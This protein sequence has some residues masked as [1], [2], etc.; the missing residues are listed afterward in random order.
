[1]PSFEREY[2]QATVF[3]RRARVEPADIAYI[4]AHTATL[5]PEPAQW[6]MPALA[7]GDGFQLEFGLAGVRP[8]P[9][10]IVVGT[11][12]GGWL[13]QLSTQHL[14]VRHQQ[15]VVDGR[16]SVARE[17]FPT[18]DAFRDAV[19][20]ACDALPGTLLAS[21]W[22]TRLA[23][24][25]AMH[26]GDLYP[27]S[28]VGE[29]IGHGARSPHPPADGRRFV[30]VHQEMEFETL[31]GRRYVWNDT[32]RTGN[33]FRPDGALTTESAAVF[34]IELQT[35]APEPAPGESTPQLDELPAVAPDDLR[36]FFASND[37]GM[38]RVTQRLRARLPEG[39]E[40]DE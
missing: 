9:Q 21:V 31:A 2:W 30:R 16:R 1:M 27:A 32:V 10:D 28:V 3:F 11:S 6:Q 12:T 40:F 23:A 35:A 38:R 8:V 24:N 39:I 37:L 33:W 29:I 14:I 15:R 36:E 34:T 20:V 19:I 4:L 5:L 17:L 18:A 22:R 26:C 13:L 7:G 25:Y